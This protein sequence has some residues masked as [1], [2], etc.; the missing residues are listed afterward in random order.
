MYCEKITCYR[1]LYS[2]LVIRLF[3]FLLSERRI[4]HRQQLQP[5]C[6][7]ITSEWMNIWFSN[8]YYEST[9]YEVL[10][11]TVMQKQKNPFCFF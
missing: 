6:N 10:L 5:A 4:V 3:P 2:S 1:M 7:F 9:N 11:A 8:H